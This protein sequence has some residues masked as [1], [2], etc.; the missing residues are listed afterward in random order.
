MNK[1]LIA[2]ATL[3]ALAGFAT[4]AAAQDVQ[5][6]AVTPDMQAAQDTQDVPVTEDSSKAWTY[7][8][9]GP[10]NESKITFEAPRDLTWPPEGAPM[11]VVTSRAGAMRGVPETSQELIERVNAPTL[12]ITTMP[13]AQA[14]H[15]MSGGRY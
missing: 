11:P 5:E 13:P 6:P 1:R 2:I 4:G 10:G 14:Q 12:I 15:I 9:I 8:I 7:E 3:A